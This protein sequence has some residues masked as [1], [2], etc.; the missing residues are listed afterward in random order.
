MTLFSKYLNLSYKNIELT[1]LTPAL[2]SELSLLGRDEAIWQGFDLPEGHQ[3][4][5]YTAYVENAW[6]DLQAKK[7]YP[8]VVLQDGAIVGSSSFYKFD[9]KQHSISI[10][11]T[12]LLAN[13]W[14]GKV[15]VAL[16][17]LMLQHAFEALNIERAVFTVDTSNARSQ[18]ALVKL[19]AVR[20]GVARH[21]VRRGDGSFAS[22]V[23]FSV[24]Q[25]EWA[26]VCDGLLARLE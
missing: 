24:L 20:E 14:G 5:K 8:L 10:G 1:F 13:V 4:E 7:R 2:H 25:K 23:V 26:S 11:Y 3:G 9:D 15:N 16:K 12:W 18:A 22:S 21:C 19:G 6:D 17:Y